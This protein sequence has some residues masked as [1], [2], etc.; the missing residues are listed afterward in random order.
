MLRR[1]VLVFACG[2][3][4]TAAFCSTTSTTASVQIASK[5]WLT[6]MDAGDYATSWQQAGIA[7]RS[8]VTV[9]HWT[10]VSGAV[11]TPLG[12]VR[13]R[14]SQDVVSTTTLPGMPDGQYATIKFETSFTHKASA[15]ETV[16]MACE[17]DGQWRVIGC[18][19]H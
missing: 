19:I 13:Q 12:A 3:F 4:S 10:Q 9:Q 8:S 7:F 2:L 15:T 18:F 14:S 1:S 6:L 5:Q 17:P 11:R 16:T